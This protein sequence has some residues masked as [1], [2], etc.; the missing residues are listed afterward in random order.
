MKTS[1][2]NEFD[3]EP[4]SLFS[5][6][7]DVAHKRNAYYTLRTYFSL[8]ERT[9][10]TLNIDLEELK[11]GPKKILFSHISNHQI[12]PNIK[13]AKFGGDFGS[14]S[15]EFRAGDSYNK[16]KEKLET[17]FFPEGSITK[18]CLFGIRDLDHRDDQILYMCEHGKPRSHRLVGSFFYK[19]R[20][21]SPLEFLDEVS[22]LCRENYFTSCSSGSLFTGPEL[23][24]DASRERFMEGVD[25]NKGI[26]KIININWDIGT[27]R[28]WSRE[29][30]NSLSEEEKER[31]LR[32]IGVEVEYKIHCK[33]N[34]KGEYWNKI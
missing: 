31:V 28:A 9:C 12:T 16:M 19:K 23:S 25:L 32:E 10:E 22:N 8:I 34:V 33:C 20:S 13:R 1:L 5:E 11:V 30:L 6:L 4:I 17:Y 7:R 26:L 2:D 27:T 18:D 3:R 24:I 15:H 21:D 29:Y 14:Y